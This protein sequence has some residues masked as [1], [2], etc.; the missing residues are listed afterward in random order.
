[1][2][3]A[4]RLTPEPFPNSTWPKAD[5]GRLCSIYSK[6]GR[7]CPE[8]QTCGNPE[9]YGLTSE[10]DGAYTNLGINQGVASFDDFFQS[11][12]AVF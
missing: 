2:Y 10:Q 3:N 7:K 6:G 8:S 1:M 5:D 12:L 11:I 9:Q 4:C